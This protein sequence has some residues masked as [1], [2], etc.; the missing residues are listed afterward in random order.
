MDTLLGVINRKN[1]NK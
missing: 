1:R